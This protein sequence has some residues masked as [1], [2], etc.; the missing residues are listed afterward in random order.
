MP[1]INSCKTHLTPQSNKTCFTTLHRSIVAGLLTIAGTVITTSVEAASITSY[2]ISGTFYNESIYGAG[3]DPYT[4]TSD[5]VIIDPYDDIVSGTDFTLTFDLD[6]TIPGAPLGSN[7]SKFSSAVSNLELMFDSGTYIGWDNYG[8]TDDVFAFNNAGSSDQ[9]SIFSTP[10]YSTDIDNLSIYDV[11]NNDYPE[12]L[13][14]DFL[15]LTLLDTDE[16]LY[17]TSPPE[18]VAFNGTEFEITE[19]NLTWLGDNGVYDYTVFGEVNSITVSA[20]P[21]PSALWL[22]GSGLFAFVSMAARSRKKT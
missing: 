14:L 8:T 2:T 15:E 11:D 18:L 9:W 3:G 22:F 21:L 17:S 6:D 5:N 19:M 4:P 13:T 12:S 20:V 1:E 7:G 10:Y 16:A